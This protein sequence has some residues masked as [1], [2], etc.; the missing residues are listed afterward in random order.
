VVIAMGASAVALGACGSV[1]ARSGRATTSEGGP[2]A[3][4]PPVAAAGVTT[5]PTVPI[6]TSTTTSTSTT[7]PTSVPTTPVG[8]ATGAP[9][10]G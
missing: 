9:A 5:A 7:A 6:P 4:Q 2:I 10:H 8:P 3:I 1:P